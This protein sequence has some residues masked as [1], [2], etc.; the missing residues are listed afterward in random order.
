M[1]L[2]VKKG[3]VKSSI[4]ARRKRRWGRCVEDENIIRGESEEHVVEEE[5]GEVEYHQQ[6]IRGYAPNEHWI[7]V[8][9]GYVDAEYDDTPTSDDDCGVVNNLDIIYY[10][11]RNNPTLCEGCGQTKRGQEIQ[12]LYDENILLRKKYTDLTKETE[13]LRER[14]KQLEENDKQN[15][16]TI[17]ALEHQQPRSMDDNKK[18]QMDVLG[19]LLLL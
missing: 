3:G 9:G 5:A 1:V 16:G 2:V 14:I 12:Q 15:K 7:N 10:Y 6:Q 4:I 19:G 17:T 8:I 11:I 18:H 13:I